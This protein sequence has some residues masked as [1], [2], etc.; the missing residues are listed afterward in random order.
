MGEAQVVDGYS[1]R[2]LHGGN[3]DEAMSDAIYKLLIGYGPHYPQYFGADM[4][5][6]MGAAHGAA[7][8]LDGLLSVVAVSPDGQIVSHGCIVYDP[9]RPEV[10]LLGAVFTHEVH[11]KKGLS[12]KVCTACVAAWDRARG[13]T[14]SALVLG[15]GSPHAAR[16]YQSEGFV[17][18]LG[19]LEGNKKGYNP[20]DLSEWLMLRWRPRAVQRELAGGDTCEA[21]VFRT[22]FFQYDGRPSSFRVEQLSRRHWSGLVLLFTAFPGDSKLPVARISDGLESEEAILKLLTAADSDASENGTSGR[23]PYLIVMHAETERIHGLSVEI[24]YKGITVDMENI[25]LP[26]EYIVPGCHGAA[27]ALRHFRADAI[28]H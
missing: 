10:G 8:G 26:Q 7:D 27:Q 6:R 28:I 14:G 12:R 13:E 23:S 18:L 19:G 15:T 21:A 24:G 4:R 11:R 3:I 1:I 9:A 20:D 2:V 5:C 25:L 22:D 17:H 16:I